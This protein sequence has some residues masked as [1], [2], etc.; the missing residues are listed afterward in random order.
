M[1]R[2]VQVVLQGFS[3]SASEIFLEFRNRFA[4][5]VDHLTA[6]ALLRRQAAANA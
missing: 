1:S 2:P 5:P 6:L 4:I 3:F